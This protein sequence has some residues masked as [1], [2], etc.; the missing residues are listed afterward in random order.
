MSHTCKTCSEPA[1]V[2]CSMCFTTLYCSKKCMDE[3]KDNHIGECLNLSEIGVSLSSFKPSN[4]AKNVK[5]KVKGVVK[6]GSSSKG[7][8]PV[9]KDKKLEAIEMGKKNCL[10]VNDPS[11]IWV[12]TA[13]KTLEKL[14]RQEKNEDVVHK[15]YMELL[16]DYTTSKST[17]CNPAV[18]VGPGERWTLKSR[19]DAG[20]K[21]EMDWVLPEHLKQTEY[22]LEEFDVN[23]RV[24]QKPLVEVHDIRPDS[25]PLKEFLRNQLGWSVDAVDSFRLSLGHRFILPEGERFAI[26]SEGDDTKKFLYV[27]ARYNEGT[28]VKIPFD[29]LCKGYRELNN[30]TQQYWS[31]GDES[32]VWILKA[33]T[34]INRDTNVYDLE[35]KSNTG[36]LILYF[37]V[38]KSDETETAEVEKIDFL[39]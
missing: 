11:G 35:N 16:I 4:V 37:N 19:S 38:V 9:V 39:Y 3:D 29:H 6:K 28:S 23:G 36:L 27:R 1:K 10:F 15:P 31:S 14:I 25:I 8:T 21:R 32:F 7:K 34:V 24:L 18:R 33:D 13:P 2:M 22:D 30:E 20:L 5:K 12:S 26:T 17:P